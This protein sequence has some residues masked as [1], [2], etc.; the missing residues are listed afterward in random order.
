TWRN[1][2][3]FEYHRGVLTT[4]AETKR[5][6]RTTEE[7]H[8]DAEKFSALSTLFGK[9]YPAND[10]NG[11]WQR[12][13][14]DDFHDIFPGSGIAVNYVDCN[15]AGTLA[16]TLVDIGQRAG[17]ALH[18]RFRTRCPQ[19]C[20]FLGI[21]EQYWLYPRERIRARQ[22]RLTNRLRDRRF[23]QAQPNGSAGAL[24]N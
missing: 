7:L 17:A 4:Q 22:S 2:M 11:A 6:I 12:L 16:V 20:V 18:D 23:R 5:L 9:G 24:R 3:Y 15:R 1:E 19:T 8:L 13:L 14:F 10:F 21:G